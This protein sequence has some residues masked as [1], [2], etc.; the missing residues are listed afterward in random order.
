MIDCGHE[1]MEDGRCANCGE[2]TEDI[3]RAENKRLKQANL[4]PTH[5]AAVLFAENKRLQ[6]ALDKSNALLMDWLDADDD[7]TEL[8]HETE[9]TL[10]AGNE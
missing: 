7:D 3:L 5:R 9:K 4:I 10:G 6:E 1:Y 8:I 2:S